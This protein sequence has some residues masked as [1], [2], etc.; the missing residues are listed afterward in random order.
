MSV[1]AKINNHQMKNIKVRFTKAFLTKVDELLSD[2]YDDT[3]TKQDFL[4]LFFLLERYMMSDKEHVW[5]K[6][7][8]E[9]VR[10]L[11]QRKHGKRIVSGLI[12]IAI[13]K[14]IL[15]ATDYHFDVHDKASSRT[16]EYR[17]TDYFLNEVLNEELSFI[18]EDMSNSFYQRL[19]KNNVPTKPHAKAQ[20]DLL[21][22]DR[23]KID[24]IAASQWLISR[25][26]D[27]EIS[28]N[29][30]HIHQ[31][32][33]L[34]L[35]DKTGIFCVEDDKTGRVYTNFSCMKK[36][37]R[38]YCT[39]DG[40]KLIGLDLKSA[41]PYLLASEM[42]DNNRCDDVERFYTTVTT[43]DLYSYLSLCTST[44]YTRDESKTEF[45]RYLY[46][47]NRGNVPY[48]DLMKELFQDVHQIVSDTKRKLMQNGTNLALYLQKKESDIFIKGTAELIEEGLL[49]VHDSVYFK[50]GLESR[51]RDRLELQFRTFNKTNYTLK[52]CI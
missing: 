32:V 16:R 43:N 2:S 48:K 34:S 24:V 25:A 37:L 9:Y 8:I 19:Q 39:I 28:L 15:F 14:N 7:S 44:N 1:Y 50:A 38:K 36:E 12:D 46:S 51:T 52:P 29:K 3:Y 21:M 31:R 40:E 18:T 13:Q 47:D 27:G 41:Q 20:Y 30:Y 42:L 33:L 35:S 10:D 26:I 49:T 11:F 45:M 4:Q 22:S 23:F 6:F 5:A 17:Y